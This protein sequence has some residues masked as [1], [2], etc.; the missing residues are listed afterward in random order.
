MGTQEKSIRISDKV[1]RKLTKW[2]LDFNFK[3]IDEL[4]KRMLKI[5]NLR[6]LEK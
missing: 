1:W 6:E 5:V 4:I 2:K 3:S